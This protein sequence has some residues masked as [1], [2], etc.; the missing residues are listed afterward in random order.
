MHPATTAAPP[1]VPQ[2]REQLAAGLEIGRRAAVRQV[3]L[4]NLIHVPS[5]TPAARP[6]NLPPAPGTEARAA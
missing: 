3:H 2:L 5:C 4:D 1:R 6:G